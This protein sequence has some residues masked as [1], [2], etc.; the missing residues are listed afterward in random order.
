MR[1]SLR[2]Q[3]RCYCTFIG[4]NHGND[5]LDLK[6]ALDS[7]N[8]I[9]KRKREV[10]S[11]PIRRIT[12][13]TSLK[14]MNSAEMHVEAFR[15][16]YW[17]LMKFGKKEVSKGI[18]FETISIERFIDNT[19]SVD[20]ECLST[21][22]IE[23]AVLLLLRFGRLRK[24]YSIARYLPFKNGIRD[25]L[26]TL[27]LI[28]EFYVAK[29]QLDKVEVILK[30][31]KNYYKTNN[32]IHVLRLEMRYYAEDSNYDLVLN[33]FMRIKFPDTS[34][35]ARLISSAD[36]FEDGLNAF[37]FLKKLKKR[38]CK[39]CF[40]AL[41]KSAWGEWDNIAVEEKIKGIHKEWGSS[42]TDIT[43]VAIMK[44][45]L[46]AKDYLAVMRMSSEY[47]SG[48][49]PLTENVAYCVIQ[50]I[51]GILDSP[52]LQRTFGKSSSELVDIA[53]GTFK[54][55]CQLQP[56]GFAPRTWSAVASVYAVV[57]DYENSRNIC[58]LAMESS[59]EVTPMFKQFLI[60][61]HTKAGVEP[62]NEILNCLQYRNRHRYSD[63]NDNSIIFGG[64]LEKFLT[65]E[66]FI[67]Q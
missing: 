26:R 1:I 47:S 32:N 49:H 48:F 43:L 24:S 31:L 64:K 12:K 62:T 59:I 44:L 23:H 27:T 65:S 4:G 57:G 29:R 33:S 38:P 46:I 3:S 10:V 67:L 50:A 52:G 40:G 14:E 25:A 37:M 39:Y 19:A 2:T 61:S 56:R 58:Y 54:L 66:T 8:D 45:H 51:R 16:K 5:L 55:L 6:K 63:W 11:T 53:H 21:A 60:E 28:A 17:H 22:L 13:K 18:S 34:D 7:G 9:P 20:P 35:I 30:L 36:T 41:V 42:P 15:R